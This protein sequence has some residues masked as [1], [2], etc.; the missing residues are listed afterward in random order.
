MRWW[1]AFNLALL[2]KRVKRK[3]LAHS[4]K[5]CKQAGNG[6]RTRTPISLFIKSRLSMQNS[7]RFYFH[8]G[9]EAAFVAVASVETCRGS[10]AE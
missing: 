1:G 9:P 5:V 3:L 10:D 7:S 6:W 4:V 2:T 8:I